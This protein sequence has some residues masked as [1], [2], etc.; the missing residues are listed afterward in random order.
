MLERY[1][2]ILYENQDE[3]IEKKSRFIATIKP[4][5]TEEEAIGF[6][7][8]ISKKYRDSRHN[9]FAYSIGL[10][11]PIERY[12][13]DGEP[14]GTAGMPILEVIRGNK[15][16]N[17]AI[18]V[19]RYFGGTLLGTGGLVRAYGGSAK[20]AIDTAIKVDKVL[21]HFVDVKVDYTYTGKLENDIRN[22]KHL[23]YETEYLDKVTYKVL[24]EFKEIDK[25]H[26]NIVDITHSNVEIKKQGLYYGY[27]IN[28]KTIIEKLDHLC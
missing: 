11:Y 28:D 15:L 1:T 23:I 3:L 17:V 22:N 7:E 14:S 24:V 19:T 16:K 18:V 6:I 20:I 5:C 2:T 8:E 4:I 10:D 13:D 12:S 26:E 25:F 27:I 9:V 21:Y